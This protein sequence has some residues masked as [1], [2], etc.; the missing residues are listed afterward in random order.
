M[1][2]VNQG[3]GG[4]GWLPGHRGNPGEGSAVVGGSTVPEVVDGAFEDPDGV[5]SDTVDLSPVNFDPGDVMFLLL[6]G[7]PS[8]ALETPPPGWE[9]SRKPPDQ[10]GMYLYSRRMTGNETTVLLSE[11]TTARRTLAALRNVDAEAPRGWYEDGNAVSATANTVNTNTLSSSVGAYDTA[12]FPPD[13]SL[14][15]I[16]TNI[17][18]APIT[19][20]APDAGYVQVADYEPPL[21]YVNVGTGKSGFVQ[22]VKNIEQ[23]SGR[24]MGV[25][26]GELTAAG[27]GM[28]TIAVGAPRTG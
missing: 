7:P 3:T 24:R 28:M 6:Y 25:Q 2:G 11:P 1:T 9:N 26:L 20:Y 10:N 4:T 18:D 8:T 23:K 15:T 13:Y 5:A 21:Q 16:G 14:V 19:P 12:L 22:V 27:A 17:T